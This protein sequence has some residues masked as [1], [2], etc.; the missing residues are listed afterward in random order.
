M[1]HYGVGQQPALK[2][3]GIDRK[4]AGP[5]W[6]DH[7]PRSGRDAHR[8]PQGAGAG[9]G[10]PARPARDQGAASRKAIRNLAREFDKEGMT[11]LKDPGIGSRDMGGL[12]EVA[13]RGRPRRARL[14]PL[15]RRANAVEVRETLVAR[16][17]SVT[18][19]TGD[20]R[21]TT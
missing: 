9:A 14:R 10:E 11:G 13:G 5:G 15:E 6:R 18:R 2:L 16:I 17:G 1:G 4:H 20:W 7:R 3:A 21:P 8:R 12:P 19:H